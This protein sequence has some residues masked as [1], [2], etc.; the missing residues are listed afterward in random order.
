M[1]KIETL[2]QDI[3][4]LILEENT[5]DE[6]ALDAMMA[7]IRETVSNLIKE[8]PQ[9][10][11]REVKVRPSNYGKPCKRALWY[12]IN[13][14]QEKDE[15]KSDSSTYIKFTVGHIYEA[16]MLFLAQQ[17]GHAVTHQQME[18]V[19]EETGVMGHI[20]ALIDGE[21]IDCKSA[22]P[23]AFKKYLDG[24]YST[25]DD[26]GYIPQLAWYRNQLSLP[27]AFLWVVDKSSGKMTLVEV[28][29]ST[30]P[31]I[32]WYMGEVLKMVDNPEPPERQWEDV[33]DGKSGNR[34]LPNECGFCSFK[35][36]CWDGLRA[37]KYSNGV[38][39]LTEVSKLPKV[40]EIV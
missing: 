12:S 32:K 2:L 3:D 6:V 35:N 33:E 17:S 9:K 29:N 15:E 37:F 19:D 22:S 21:L 26:F 28:S 38:R 10:K 25:K 39:Y 40:E 16:L 4:S 36:T 18:I 31:N 1:K 27:R 5:V 34:C 11:E 24:S 14:P 13:T 23:Y 30:M 7:S 20:D 8:A